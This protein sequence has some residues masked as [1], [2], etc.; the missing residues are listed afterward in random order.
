MNALDAAQV[1]PYAWAAR[2]HPAYKSILCDE[3]EHGDSHDKRIPQRVRLRSLGV[4]AP[5]SWIGCHP[6]QNHVHVSLGGK[7]LWT[8]VVKDRD[9]WLALEPTFVAPVLTKGPKAQLPRTHWM[10]NEDRSHMN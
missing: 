7:V 4:A 8:W 9:R 6:L 1:K 5:Y 10:M 3:L 2:T